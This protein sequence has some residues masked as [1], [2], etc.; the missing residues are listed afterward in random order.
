[1]C[2]D[3]LSF[4]VTSIHICIFHVAYAYTHMRVQAHTNNE[5]NLGVPCETFCSCVESK[6]KPLIQLIEAYVR[7]KINSSSYID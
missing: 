1:M 3:A 6:S 2:S 5:C 4:D 7:G